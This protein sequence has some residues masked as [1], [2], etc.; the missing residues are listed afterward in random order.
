MKVIKGE[1]GY[2]H[3]KGHF[4]SAVPNVQWSD[5][6]KTIHCSYTGLN[7]FIIRHDEEN[8]KAPYFALYEP[9]PLGSIRAAFDEVSRAFMIENMDIYLSLSSSADSNGRHQDDHHVAIAQAIGSTTYRFDD[10]YDAVMTPGDSLYIPAWVY[11]NQIA[12]SPR[13]NLSFGIQA[14]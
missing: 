7:D 4:H 13:V 14:P 6:I 5:V 10:G 9:T 1:S 3:T 11:H 2:V 12:N 8:N